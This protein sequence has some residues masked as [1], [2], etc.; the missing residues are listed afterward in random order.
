MLDIKTLFALEK[1]VLSVVGNNDGGKVEEA[2][3]RRVEEPHRTF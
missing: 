2:S 1:H 3:G